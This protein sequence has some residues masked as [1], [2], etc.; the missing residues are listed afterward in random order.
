MKIV[1]SSTGKK[2]ESEVDA[3]FGRC[4]YFAIIDIDKEKKEI[5][6][7]KFLENKSA[8]QFGGAGITAAEFVGNQE[9]EAVITMNMGPKAFSVM[10]QIGIE[11][12]RGQGKIKHVINQFL[13]GKLEKIRRATGPTFMG[14]NKK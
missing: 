3:R 10:A 4:P 2:L 12:Y 11:V 6:S 14:K 7:S 1:I 9:V 13:D 5:T 8:K